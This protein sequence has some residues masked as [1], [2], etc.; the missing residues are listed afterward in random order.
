M[1]RPPAAQ[2][3]TS[4]CHFLTLRAAVNHTAG[5]VVLLFGGP[6]HLDAGGGGKGAAGCRPVDDVAAAAA[7]DVSFEWPEVAG[8][9]VLGWHLPAEGAQAEAV[10]RADGCGGLQ[11]RQRWALP[12][13]AV[14]AGPG[15]LRLDLSSLAHRLACPYGL[16]V[17]W[18]AAQQPAAAA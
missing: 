12:P 7:A 3:G 8:V 13:G 16:R 15:G 4:L 5:E 9:E 11:V 17:S 6:S 2:V 14:G 1:P 18:H 10:Q